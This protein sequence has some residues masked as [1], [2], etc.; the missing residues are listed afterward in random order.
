MYNK[1]KKKYVKIIFNYFKKYVK[2]VF[3]YFKEKSYEKKQKNR[4]IGFIKEHLKLYIKENI[5]LKERKIKYDIDM[6]KEEE[7]EK[8]Y[9][10]GQRGDMY[11]YYLNKTVKFK[12]TL[13]YEI[14]AFRSLSQKIKNKEHPREYRWF[15]T[16]VSYFL[17]KYDVLKLKKIV[18][19]EKYKPNKNIDEFIIHF[20]EVLLE[21]LEYLK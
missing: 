14:K 17:E 4:Y 5:D 9:V 8:K 18:K 11:N 3:N 20:R 1:N 7:K 16:E 21:K 13:N 12:P 19:K 10:L 2:I 6:K 15:L